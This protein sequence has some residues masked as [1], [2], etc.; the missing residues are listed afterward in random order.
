MLLTY[1]ACAQA[2]PET[3]G[4]AARMGGVSPADIDALLIYLEVQRRKS[5]TPNP[6]PH[7]ST[8]Q[9]RDALIAAAYTAQAA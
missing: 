4:Q 7:M 5:G 2:Q 8:R 1:V 3:V 9:R 6:S